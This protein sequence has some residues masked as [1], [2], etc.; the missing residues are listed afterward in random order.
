MASG[1]RKAT[2]ALSVRANNESVNNVQ[3]ALGELSIAAGL[4]STDA[5]NMQLAVGEAVSNAVTHAFSGEGAGLIEVYGAVS[6]K[7][8]EFTV[9]NDG[10]GLRGGHGP[11]GLGLGLPL[12]DSLASGLWIEWGRNGVTVHMS[13]SFDAR[14]G[15]QG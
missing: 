4:L 13:F 12:M 10:A 6:P 8:A 15:P 1:D 11:A 14:E 7:G 9:R 5:E 2:L 3:R